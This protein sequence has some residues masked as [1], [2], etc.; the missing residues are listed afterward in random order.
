MSEPLEAFT[1]SR[2]EAVKSYYSEQS[3]PCPLTII[4]TLA[5]M[6]VRKKISLD[7]IVH[8]A[9]FGSEYAQSVADLVLTVEKNS[10]QSTE[11][12]PEHSL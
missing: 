9:F 3:L 10:A 12:S 11:I 2:I 7:Q 8:P 1:R 4:D 6:H 5:Q